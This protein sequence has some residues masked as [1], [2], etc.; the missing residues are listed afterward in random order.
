ME[1]IIRIGQF[2]VCVGCGRLRITCAFDEDD[3][4]LCS[5]CK[6]SQSISSSTD[7]DTWESLGSPS[8]KESHLTAAPV[9]LWDDESDDGAA[10]GEA[11]RST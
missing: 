10:A 4:P 7:E 8:N 11:N 6:K 2:N 9:R 1:A 3:L 5:S